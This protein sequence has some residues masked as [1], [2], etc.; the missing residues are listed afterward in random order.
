MEKMQTKVNYKSKI[1]KGLSNA[2]VEKM[3]HQSNDQNPIEIVAVLLCTN[4]NSS[5]K[6]ILSLL[7][8]NALF[9]IWLSI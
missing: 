9:C 8:N 2:Q 5:Y 3:L 4:D 6:G 1:I 7:Q